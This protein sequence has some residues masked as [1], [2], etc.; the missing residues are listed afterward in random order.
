MGADALKDIIIDDADIDW[1]ESVL[2]GISFDESRRTIIKTLDSLDVQACPGSG[3]TTVLIAKLAIMARKWPHTNRGICVLSHTNV[4][5]EEIQSR[6]GQTPEGRKLLAYPHFIGTLHSFCNRYISMPWIRS[7]GTP[8]NIIDT[9][10]VVNKRWQKLKY[11]SRFYLQQHGFDEKICEAKNLPVTLNIGCRPE[12]NTYV[13]LLAIISDS[14]KRGEFTFDEMFLFAD[15]ALSHC[16]FLPNSIQARFPILFIDETQDTSIQQWNL[17]KRGFPD[18]SIRQGF[19]DVNQAIYL[20]YQRDEEANEF[21]RSGAL[22]ISNSLRFSDKIASLSSPLALHQHKM[23]GNNTA[24]LRND[25]KHCIFLFN[26]N[27]INKLIPAYGKYLLECFSDE[28]LANNNKYGC[29][30]ISMVHRQDGPITDK[31]QLPKSINDYWPRYNPNTASRSANPTYLIDYFRAGKVKFE[32]THEAESLVDWVARGLRRY[33]NM[34]S[35]YTIPATTNAF[36]AILNQLPIADQQSFRTA[37]YHLSFHSIDDESAW[38]AVVTELHSL[39]DDKFAISSICDGI[40][41]WQAPI[42]AQSDFTINVFKYIC[43]ETNRSVDIKLGSIHS[44]KGRTHLATMVIES[45]WH[46]HNILSI[47]GHLRGKTAKKIGK[48]NATRLKCH[49]VALTRPKALVCVALPI[50]SVDD[51]MKKE[52]T[53]Q[54]WNFVVV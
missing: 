47:L 12:S 1:V 45:F 40:L 11:G 9:D 19:G 52:L 5:Q 23:S 3:K 8:V 13:D 16:R 22:E 37:F 29:H 51:I 46:E 48:R 2:S 18:T 42:A 43:P 53:D 54:G 7:Q 41:T 50:D 14:H 25:N 39:C 28:E 10:F 36:H 34:N 20:S 27:Q 21:P 38:T 26:N 33:I 32:E 15:S 24:F 6:L 35:E 49:Y 31:K 4:A 44:V 30:F 17:I